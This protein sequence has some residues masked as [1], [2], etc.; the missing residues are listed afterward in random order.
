MAHKLYDDYYL[1]RL[2]EVE[3][4][5][6]RKIDLIGKCMRSL[7]K[8]LSYFQV[9]EVEYKLRR[10]IEKIIVLLGLVE[11]TIFIQFN[12]GCCHTSVEWHN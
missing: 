11:W 5:S 6:A 8:R 1:S 12:S 4:K 2:N 9:I 3:P 7:G 10:T